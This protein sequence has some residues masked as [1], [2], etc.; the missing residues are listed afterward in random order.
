MPATAHRK[1]ASRRYLS[2][3]RGQSAQRGN[4]NVRRNSRRPKP[5]RQL[6]GQERGLQVHE[7][8]DGKPALDARRAGQLDALAAGLEEPDEQPELDP[9]RDVQQEEGDLERAPP[10]L[11]RVGTRAYAHGEPPVFGRRGAASRAK[12][13]NTSSP[14]RR[15]AG[16]S[17]RAPS[18]STA[19]DE[20]PRPT[21][22]ANA[23][24]IS[25]TCAA[26]TSRWKRSPQ[27]LPLRK[28][29]TSVRS[30]RAR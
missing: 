25:S 23:R 6:A 19:V 26:S 24:A 21:S 3:R 10:A 5:E 7:R 18:A 16:V 22:S 27:A 17:R 12:L 29:C 2:A 8:G 30:L 9:D 4:A 1:N 11:R 28:A 15:D 14:I 20:P 13:P